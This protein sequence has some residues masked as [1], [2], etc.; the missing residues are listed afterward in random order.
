MSPEI[1]SHQTH[2][3]FKSDIWALGVI[4]YVLLS[5]KFPFKAQNDQDLYSKIRKSIF[6]FPEGITL[7]AKSILN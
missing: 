4:L 7:E 3:Y 1:V 2:N 5:G 6:T